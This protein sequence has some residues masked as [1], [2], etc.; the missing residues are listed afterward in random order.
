[1]ARLRIYLVCYLW[2]LGL[3]PPREKTSLFKGKKKKK[4]D[5]K[6]LNWHIGM[7]M[8]LS[9]WQLHLVKLNCGYWVDKAETDGLGFLWN[10]WLKRRKWL[11][12]LSFQWCQIHTSKGVW[13]FDLSSRMG[14]RGP[15]WPVISS[16]CGMECCLEHPL[17]TRPVCH[18]MS[19]T[20][21]AL[22]TPSQWVT[23]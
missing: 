4:E 7:F 16:T 2:W 1:M 9:E 8:P 11:G 23:S 3:L 5:W 14:R 17:S 22:L 21:L 18:V 19:F 10:I 20:Y 13:M 12:P 15:P 6:I